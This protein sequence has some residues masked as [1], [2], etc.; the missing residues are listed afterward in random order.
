MEDE[1]GD[2]KTVNLE[3]KVETL[4]VLCRI[5]LHSFAARFSYILARIS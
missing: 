2:P 1:E 4:S 3:T 5:L